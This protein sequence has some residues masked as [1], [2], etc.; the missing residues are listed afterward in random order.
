MKNKAKKIIALLSAAAL[1]FLGACSDK[2]ADDITADGTVEVAVD[3]FTA[4]FIFNENGL[5]E[6]EKKFYDNQEITYEY[7][8]CYEYN[9]DN[10]ITKRYA[11]DLEGNV[12]EKH[13]LFEI[14]YNDG[15]RLTQINE[16]KYR[17]EFIYGENGKLET[18]KKYENNKLSSY[19]NYE[20]DEN[21]NC[22]KEI[23]Y[24]ADNTLSDTTVYTYNENSLVVSVKTESSNGD[25]TNEAAYEYNSDGL[26]SKLTRNKSQE[27]RTTEYK[28]KNGTLIEEIMT[29]TPA[30]N[31]S[32]TRTR[33]YVTSY[34]YLAGGKV[35]KF[36]RE[37]DGEVYITDTYSADEAKGNFAEFENF[38]SL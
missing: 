30:E 24:S 38:I 23:R 25:V 13:D 9:A 20:Y 6:K 8:E 4:E 35:V 21:G 19:K 33:S 36:S 32:D 14:Y 16:G 28:Y 15:G 29:V 17:H 31:S 2:T 26:V 22:V 7:Y 27:T 18:Y 12:L 5:I 34:E 1:L 10:Q 37:R 3:N 11:T